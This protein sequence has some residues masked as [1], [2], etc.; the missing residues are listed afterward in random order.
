MVPS[1]IFK[2]M[3]EMDVLPLIVFSLLLGA[4][5]SVLGEAGQPAVNVFGSLNAA[6]MRMVHWLMTIAPFGIFGL[7]SGRIGRAGGFEGFLPELVAVGK[8]SFTV[9]L[10]L[11]CTAS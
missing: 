11:G 3:A 5:L 9:L 8:Y 10:V 1:N 6:I 4:V 2:S 7:I